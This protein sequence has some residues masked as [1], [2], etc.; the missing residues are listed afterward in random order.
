[1]DQVL[2]RLKGSLKEGQLFTAKELSNA[3]RDLIFEHFLMMR[4]LPETPNGMGI[5][6]ND[7]ATF[8]ALINADNHLELRTLS[9]KPQ[10]GQQWSFLTSAEDQIG[11]EHP[12]AF[13][14]KFGYLTSDPAQSGT[15]L[16]IEVFLHLP[17]LIHTKQIDTALANAE[18]EELFF[19]GITGN[20]DEPVGDLV[21]IEN[22][23]S[24]GVSEEAIMHSIENAATKLIGAEK[25]MREHLK[26]EKRIEIKDLI[27]KAYGLIV[28]SY[29]LEAKEA[30]NLISLM[31][32]GL[33]LGYVTGVTNEK[34]DHLFFG[35]RRGHLSHHYPDTQDP[36]ELTHKR[37]DFL[38]QELQ[39]M[40]LSEE[41]Q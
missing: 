15:G 11:K 18:E 21:V 6:L 40:A 27:S 35:C 19:T 38:Q 33:E 16:T 26:K 9:V 36:K 20:V 2:A 4:T 41:M 14:P 5:F 37:A 12:F 30:L 39:G 8:C 32:L 28:H 10:W 7:D 13:S 31:K 29:Q 34:L 1:M 23:Y 3:E 22:N 17:A 24:I 25:T